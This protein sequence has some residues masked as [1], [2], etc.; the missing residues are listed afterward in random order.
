MSCSLNSFKIILEGSIIRGIIWG[1]GM[2]GLGLLLTSTLL[3]VYYFPNNLLKPYSY[4]VYFYFQCSIT[5]SSYSKYLP[6]YRSKGA[7][8]LWGLL[9]RELISGNATLLVSGLG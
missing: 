5:L 8:D 7:K 2:Y 1:L 6:C 9:Q 3:Y 4:E